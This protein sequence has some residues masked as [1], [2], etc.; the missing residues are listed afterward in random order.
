[1]RIQL[2]AGSLIV[3]GV[4]AFIAAN[5]AMTAMRSGAYSAY[6]R[7]Q[8]REPVLPG[9]IRLVALGDSS[10]QAIG[11]AQPMDGYVGLTANYVAQRTCRPVH[12]ANVSS[13]GTTADILQR[14]VRQVDLATADLVIVANSNDMEQRRQVERYRQDLMALTRLLP[15]DRTV[16]SDLPI[17]PGRQPYQAVLQEVTDAHG[18]RRAD[19]AAMFNGEGR[20]LDIFSWLPPHLNSKGYEYWF[21]AFQP[22]VDMIVLGLQR[23]CPDT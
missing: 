21:K 19:F 5:V 11:A 15:A 22:Q 7:D 16:F 18:I 4:V 12:I 23:D 8:M 1:M 2:I 10:V 9:A 3:A 13:A 6:W 17:F 20:R 14:E